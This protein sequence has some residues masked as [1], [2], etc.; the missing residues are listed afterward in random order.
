[1]AN[2][3]EQVLFLMYIDFLKEY[4]EYF[5]VIKEGLLSWTVPYTLTRRCLK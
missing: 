3:A 1:M 4:Q 2:K 5:L